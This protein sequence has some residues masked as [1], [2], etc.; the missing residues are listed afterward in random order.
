MP[1]VLTSK[2]LLEGMFI[3]HG[4]CH[5]ESRG[6]RV[7]KVSLRGKF[8]CKERK[9]GEADRTIAYGGAWRSGGKDTH[10]AT[11]NQELKNG[12][13][14]RGYVMRLRSA[15]RRRARGAHV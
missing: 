8:G 15:A 4:L 12:I 6:I 13:P 5:V 10:S 14:V 7:V 2:V 3:V 9:E 11:W 1:S